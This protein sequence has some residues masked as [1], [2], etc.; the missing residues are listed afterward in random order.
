MKLAHFIDLVTDASR[1]DLTINSIAME[2]DIPNSPD[3]IRQYIDPYNGR[4]DIQAKILRHTSDAFSEDPVRVLRIARFRARL[5][6]E[7]TVA[8][9]TKVLIY[10]IAKSGGLDE[11]TPERIWKEMSQALLEPFPRLFF[12]TL[13][14]CDALYAV[15]PE[16]YK[17]LTALESHR[18][19][20]EGNAY[21]HTM[22]CL[23]Q[24]AEFKMDLEAMF[25]VLV[26]DFGKGLTPFHRLPKHYGHDVNGVALVESFAN[27]LT[28]PSKIRD[29]SMKS[30]RYHMLM[31]KLDTIKANTYVKMFNDMQVLNDPRAVS[32]LYSVG[33]CDE[34]G[35]LGSE[36][37]SIEHLW[38]LMQKFKAYCSVK[39]I[40]V[41]PNGETDANKIQSKLQE[42]RIKA[43]DNA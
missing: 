43:V 12:D 27:R 21:K 18:W 2:S 29:R 31:H 7:W 30:T 39:F 5:G 3:G 25:A 4:A 1:R 22:L 6:P 32:I 37:N 41:F 42:A 17:L 15:F 10:N 34:R 16:I 20:P 8:A 36:N 19:H 9:E 38:V 33:I 35:R 23:T 28:V 14:E 26:H 13:L 40:D 11:L 24:A